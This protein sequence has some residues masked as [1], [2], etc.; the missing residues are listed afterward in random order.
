MKL[1]ADVQLTGDVACKY[2][3]IPDFVWTSKTFCLSGKE[4]DNFTASISPLVTVLT[5]LGACEINNKVAFKNERVK[6]EINWYCNNMCSRILLVLLS[7]Y[8]S[9]IGWTTGNSI[10]CYNTN[11][12]IQLRSVG[13]SKNLFTYFSSQFLSLICNK[14][15]T[16]YKNN[17]ISYIYFMAILRL[18]HLFFISH[19]FHKVILRGSMTE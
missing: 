15:W 4:V 13:L 2:Q 10:H 6:N 12:C 11:F 8:C 7:K 14:L 5:G 3:R 1:R 19:Y 16:T 17:P 18:V 9:L